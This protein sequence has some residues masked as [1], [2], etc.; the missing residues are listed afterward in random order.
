MVTQHSGSSS[1]FQNVLNGSSDFNVW[2]L[3]IYHS[4]ARMLFYTNTHTTYP[5]PSWE[6]MFNTALDHRYLVDM[7]YDR[8]I[9][10]GTEYIPDNLNIGTTNNTTIKIFS[11]TNTMTANIYSFKIYDNGTLIRDMI[12]VKDLSGVACMYDKV[13]G[14]FY[15]NAGTGD[16]IAGPDL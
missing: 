13:S 14:Q 12:P 5:R 9:V 8:T 11:A 7:N 3:L 10:N 15:Y 1:I 4:G 2:R 16:F 6:H